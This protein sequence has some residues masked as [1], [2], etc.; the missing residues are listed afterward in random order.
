M[1]VLRLIGDAVVAK[2]P[3]LWAWTGWPTGLL[4]T[5][6]FGLYIGAIAREAQRE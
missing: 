4:H 5:V 3:D 2:A 6:F 1:T